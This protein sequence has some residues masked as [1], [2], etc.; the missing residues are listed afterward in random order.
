[1]SRSPKLTKTDCSLSLRTRKSNQD[2]RVLVAESAGRKAGSPLAMD[3]QNYHSGTEAVPEENQGLLS[4]VI[5]MGIAEEQW[6]P[7]KTKSSFKRPLFSVVR[8]M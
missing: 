1:M 2:F 6:S 7:S 5:E 3:E 4:Q 8:Y